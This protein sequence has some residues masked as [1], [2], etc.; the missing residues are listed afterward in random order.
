M[1]H[2]FSLF[3]QTIKIKKYH[4]FV[5]MTSSI[6]QYDG[7]GYSSKKDCINKINFERNRMC[8]KLNTFKFISNFKPFKMLYYE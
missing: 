8:H 4:K 2:L 7:T 5:I 3:T 1:M 6:F